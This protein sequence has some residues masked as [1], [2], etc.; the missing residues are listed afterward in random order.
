MRKVISNTTPI[1]NLIKIGKLD[2][3]Q[4]LYNKVQISQAV[5]R[6]IE[7]GKNKDYYIDISK[8]D[9]IN[10][11][12]IKSASSRLYLY[13]LDDGEAETIILIQE[14]AADL[15]LIDE[16]IGRRFANHLNIP[17]SGTIGILIKAKESG[18]IN[19]VTPL[20]HELRNKSSWIDDN[21]F[22]KAL[23]IAGEL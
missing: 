1:L 21:L 4:K 5:F 17:V 8:I 16:K 10:I 22:K 19:S 20:L 14:Q 23:T 11:M 2:I 12:P 7:E 18:L 6:E 3:L 13:D 9:W 15:I